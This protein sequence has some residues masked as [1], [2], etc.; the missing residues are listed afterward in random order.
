MSGSHNTL[1]S[2]I[3]QW[4]RQNFGS[5]GEDIQKTMFSSKTFEKFIK[6]LHKDLKKFSKII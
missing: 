5:D 6:P 2:P 3:L 1:S 4:R